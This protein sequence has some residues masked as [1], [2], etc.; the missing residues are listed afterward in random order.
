MK[1][2]HYLATLL[3]LGSMTMLAGAASE[4]TLS[5]Y[6][7]DG[8][9]NGTLLSGVQ[10]TGT[11]AS[12]N[13]FEGTTNS[14]GIAEISGEQGTWTFTFEKDGYDPLYLKY[15]ATT[16]EDT[17][18]YLEKSSSDASTS[19]ASSQDSVDLTVYVHDG[20]I[21]G[22][23]LSGVAVTGTDASGNSF[24]EKTGSSGTAIVSGTP[25][26]WQFSFEKSGYETLYLTYNATQT[27]STAAYLEKSS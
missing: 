5:V 27:E 13:A 21:D 7:H 17:A 16:S 25:G 11:D 23:L 14:D 24:E 6:V 12:G 18:A 26:T 3:L 15:D 22:D 9:I 4:V 1:I 2:W 19:G 8:D 20:S 10:I